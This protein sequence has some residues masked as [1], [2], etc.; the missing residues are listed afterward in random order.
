VTWN[1]LRKNYSTMLAFV[2][3]TAVGFVVVNPAL[4]QKVNTVYSKEVALFNGKGDL[5]HTFQGRWYIWK[6]MV[7]K[8]V[9]APLYKKLAGDGSITSFGSHNEF[10]RVL[11]ATGVIGLLILL[12]LLSM[13][14]YR[15]VQQ[16][17]TRRSPLDLVALMLFFMWFIDALGLV[18]GAYTGYQLFVWGFIGLSVGAGEILY[19]PTDGHPDCDLSC[20]GGVGQAE[21]NPVGQVVAR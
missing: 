21:S 7:S 12:I 18:P 14:F 11:F 8:W 3:I 5:D 9:D 17:V 4:F 13:I 2:L 16:C 15:I 6:K 19:S 1:L 10:L 20:E